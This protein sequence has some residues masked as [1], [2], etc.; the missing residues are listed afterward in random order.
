MSTLD[1]QLSRPQALRFAAVAAL[2]LLLQVGIERLLGRI[3]ICACGYV[4][5]FE[6]SVNSDGNS[7]HIADWYTPSHI[8][9]GFIF[10]GLG[11]LFLR[12]Y[13]KWIWFA[14]ALALESFWEVLE[15]SPIIIDRYRSAT[16]SLNYY[17]DSILN[18]ASDTIMMM[19]GFW[20]A[21]KLP[22]KL[23][24]ALAIVAELLTLA[25]IRDNLT[26][27]VLMLIYP[28]EAIKTW[29]GQL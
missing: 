12:R 19:A 2:F 18:S 9:H 5:L 4:K 14:A 8:E 15:N 27:N 26:L 20:L 17:G 24:L 11:W 25:I 21:S 3:W 23:T 10:F 7:Q 1:A 13:P 6:A 22:W 29:Q 28:I 16:I